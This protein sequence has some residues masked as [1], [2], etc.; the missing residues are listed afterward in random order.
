MIDNI[1]VYVRLQ[2]ARMSLED[3]K[4][5]ARG[6]WPTIE[7]A[8]EEGDHVVYLDAFVLSAFEAFV[9][10]QIEEAGRTNAGR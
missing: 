4:T 5:E 9:K 7:M 1:A 3:A 6:E 8:R 10:R 2:S